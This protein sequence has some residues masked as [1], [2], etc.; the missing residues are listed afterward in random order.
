MKRFLTVRSLSMRDICM[1][2]LNYKCH[3]FSV[4]IAAQI[5]HTVPSTLICTQETP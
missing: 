4:I 3:L 2:L 5:L 1:I